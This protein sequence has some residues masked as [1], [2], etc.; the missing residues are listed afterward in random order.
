MAR[1]T[2]YDILTLEKK[3][4]KREHSRL[5]RAV[6]VTNIPVPSRCSQYVI[7]EKYRIA[8][9]TMKLAKKVY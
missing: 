3:R 4:L 9:I 2:E 7:H 6:L 5:G 8:E 1:L